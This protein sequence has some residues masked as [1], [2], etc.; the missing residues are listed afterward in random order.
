MLKKNP[1]EKEKADFCK[2][3]QTIAVL[4][5]GQI[6]SKLKKYI[7]IERE[8]NKIEKFDEIVVLSFDNFLY[9]NIYVNLY[10]MQAF[11][12]ALDPIFTS[13]NF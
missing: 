9:I 13:V 12:S 6:F 5:L 10:I 3:K 8:E 1:F 4:S 2:V 11:I 7:K